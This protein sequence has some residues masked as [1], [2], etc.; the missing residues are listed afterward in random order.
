[1]QPILPLR[2]GLPERQTHDYM[3]HGVTTLFA[4]VNVAS[5]KVIGSCK[6]RHR[7]QEYLEFLKTV[8]RKCPKGKVLHLVADNVSSH[9][10]KAVQEHIDSL[11]GRIV[12]HYTP[13]HSS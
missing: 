12:V 10:T 7:H 4:A 11:Q 6:T 3:R 5:G 8:D 1:M 13:T 2:P 9:K